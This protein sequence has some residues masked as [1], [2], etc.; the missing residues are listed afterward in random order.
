MQGAPGIGIN[1]TSVQSQGPKEVDAGWVPSLDAFSWCSA[2][3]LSSLQGLQEQLGIACVDAPK[4]VAVA[5]VHGAVDQHVAS[6][7]Q[8]QESELRCL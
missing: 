6:I 1:F 7:L 5:G 4:P 8:P 2:T 3:H